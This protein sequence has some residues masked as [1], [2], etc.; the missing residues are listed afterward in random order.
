MRRDA[1]H[2][3]HNRSA[4]LVEGQPAVRRV[5]AAGVITFGRKNICPPD[6]VPAR[7]R[8]PAV[9]VSARVHLTRRPHP[10]NGSHAAARELLRA[11]ADRRWAHQV[12]TWLAL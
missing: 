10:G 7:L 6:C 12:A 2:P 11:T 4:Y 3:D 1:W 9:S 8:V 5:S